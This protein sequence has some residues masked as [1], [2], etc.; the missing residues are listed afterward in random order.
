MYKNVHSGIVKPEN[1]S[2][3]TV[4]YTIITSRIHLLFSNENAWSSYASKLMSLKNL[5]LNE[6]SLSIQGNKVWIHF[7]KYKMKHCIY[8][9]RCCKTQ[10]ND[11]QIQGEVRLEVVTEKRHSISFYTTVN[12]VSQDVC[13]VHRSVVYWHWN[14]TCLSVM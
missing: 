14:V 9:H 10:G 2:L 5:M 7:Y 3:S 8:R 4:Q 13:W 6:K 11:Y 1:N 12:Y